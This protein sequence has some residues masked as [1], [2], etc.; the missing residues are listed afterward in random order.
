MQRS[1]A[2]DWF[3][4][5]FAT[6]AF[7]AA[8]GCSERLA[9]PKQQLAAAPERSRPSAPRSSL[10]DQNGSPATSGSSVAEAWAETNEF[11][12]PIP[13]GYRNATAEFPGGGFSVVL[14]KNETAERYQSTI[15]IRRV[16]IPGGSFDDP[17]ECEQTGRGLIHGGTDAPGTGGMLNS[18]QICNAFEKLQRSM[19]LTM[20]T[21][22]YQNS[23]TMNRDFNV[24]LQ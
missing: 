11:T 7:L 18:V 2:S 3:V 13:A 5:F 9:A 15:V 10:S 19:S 6:A 21:M 24:T 20:T 23:T 14:A 16:P 22:S 17:S 12:L 8:L 4:C 1:R